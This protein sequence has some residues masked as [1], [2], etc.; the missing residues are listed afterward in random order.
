MTS[1]GRSSRC[2][3]ITGQNGAEIHES[4]KVVVMGCPK[5][6]KAKA[7]RAGSKVGRRKRKGGSGA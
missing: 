1:V 3:A 6:H 7:R 4:T 5:G 2:T